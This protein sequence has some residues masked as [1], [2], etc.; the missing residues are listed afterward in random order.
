MPSSKLGEGDIILKG[1][2]HPCLEMQ[3]DIAFIA[4]DVNLIRGEFC[5]FSLCGKD[6]ASPFHRLRHVPD[7]HRTKHGREVHVYPAGGLMAL[8]RVYRISANRRRPRID[9]AQFEALSEINAT[10][11]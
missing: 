5:T 9:A 8:A 6:D 1:A 4:N 7:N 2:R 3:D 10:L 11:E